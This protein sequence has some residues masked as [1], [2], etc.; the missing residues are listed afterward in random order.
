MV[1]AGMS[2]AANEIVFVDI[3]IAFFCRK[4]FLFW[5]VGDRR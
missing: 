4:D 1:K 5:M 2:T 3:I